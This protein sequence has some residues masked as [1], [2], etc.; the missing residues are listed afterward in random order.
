MFAYPNIVTFE[1]E[2][3]EREIRW[4][5]RIYVHGLMEESAEYLR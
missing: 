5:K 4:A 3:F 1:Y 2:L